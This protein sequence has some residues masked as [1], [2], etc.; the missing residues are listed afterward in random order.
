MSLIVNIIFYEV[1]AFVPCI[2]L[3]TLVGEPID[4]KS[5]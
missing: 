3:I 5:L 4:H 1:F 2:H